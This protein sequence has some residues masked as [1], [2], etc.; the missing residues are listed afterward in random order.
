M[1][2]KAPKEIKKED[3]E[4]YCNAFNEYLMKTKC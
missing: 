2:N 3:Y 1:G 4:N